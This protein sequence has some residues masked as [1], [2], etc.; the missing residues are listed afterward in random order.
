VVNKWF[1]VGKW[2]DCGWYMVGNRLIF[3]R[4]AVCKW[5]VFSGFP[6]KKDQAATPFSKKEQAVI[7][8]S[9]DLRVQR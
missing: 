7:P 3:S 2:I 1:L 9:T 5:L 8:Y 6:S 4:L